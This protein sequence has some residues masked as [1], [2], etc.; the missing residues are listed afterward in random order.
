MHKEMRKKSHCCQQRNFSYEISSTMTLA[1]RLCV[2]M[3]PQFGEKA[4]AREGT[5]MPAPLIEGKM[6]RPP[7]L[8]R[9]FYRSR[10]KRAVV[11]VERS[12]CSPSK[13]SPWDNP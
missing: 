12:A 3:H 2:C 11:D 13:N 4:F 7:P 9:A 6:A 10:G 8:M 5:V 1:C